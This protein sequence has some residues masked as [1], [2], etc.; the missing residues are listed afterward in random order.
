MDRYGENIANYT[1]SSYKLDLFYKIKE[2]DMK[3][4]S[5][6]V[7]KALNEVIKLMVD[8]VIEKEKSED[9]KE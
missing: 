2:I 3:Y 8:D 6:E 7:S 9:K 4:N 5:L 1:R